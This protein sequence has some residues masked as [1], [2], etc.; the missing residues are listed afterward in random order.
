MC[1]NKL[2][3]LVR[4]GISFIVFFESMLKSQLPTETR[5]ISQQRVR[6]L[7]GCD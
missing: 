1:F 2:V 6:V 3:S 7:C 4:W 5:A